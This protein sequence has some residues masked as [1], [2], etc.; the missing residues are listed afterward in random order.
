MPLAARDMCNLGVLYMPVDLSVVHREEQ[1]AKANSRM[2][3]R[4]SKIAQF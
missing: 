3:I 2:L 4:N 1:P